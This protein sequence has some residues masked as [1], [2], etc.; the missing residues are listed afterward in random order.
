[1]KLPNV[2]GMTSV[3]LF[4]SQSSFA[5]YVGFT[6]FDNVTAGNNNSGIYDTTPDQSSSVYLTANIGADASASGFKGHGKLTTAV[7]GAL[8]DPTF[9]FGGPATIANG[10]DSWKFSSAKQLKGDIQLVNNSDSYFKFTKIHFDS[11]RAAA[12]SATTLK[13]T[14]L[15][16]PEGS[17]LI[18]KGTGN[19]IVDNKVLKTL[20][21]G[22]TETTGKDTSV[23]LG[24]PLSGTGYLAPGDKASLRFAFT[25]QTGGGFSQ[26]DNIAFEGEFYTDATLTSVATPAA[27]SAVPVPASAWLFGSALVGLIASR[28]K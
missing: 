20:T 25:G 21:W 1:M 28:R 10:N 18:H 8:N 7:S 24:A 15:A 4:A 5:A 2:I 13:L 3:L 19:E 14:Y 27:F 11:R 12:T 22:G 17:N 16:S 6:S 26:L 23:G 9:G